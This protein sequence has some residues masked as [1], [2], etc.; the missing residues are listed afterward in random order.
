M[1]QKNDHRTFVLGIDGVPHSFLMERFSKGEMPELAR[2]CKEN[3]SRRMNSVYPTVSSVAW[4]TFA[5]GKNPA[6][7]NIMGFVDREPNPFQIKIPID[8]DRRAKTIWREISEQG[9]SVIVINVPFTY[10][11]EEVNGILVSGFLCTD[12]EKASYPKDFSRYL[13]E[14]DYIIDV[15]AWL[16]KENKPAFM[17]G[18]HRALEKRFEIIFEL[19]EKKPWDYCH[20]HIMETDRLFHFFWSEFNAPGEFSAAIA[21]FFS[22]LDSFIGELQRRLSNDDSLLILSDHGFCTTQYEVQLNVWL[23]QQGLLKF[24]REKKLPLYRR[25]SLC[26]SLLPGRI[27]INLEGREERGSVKSKDYHALRHDLKQ[28]LLDFRHPRT[29]EK[30]IDKVF[31]REEIYS[32]P[33]LNDAA[34]II[35]DPCRGFDLKARVGDD[36]QLFENTHISGMHT[37]DDAFLMARN[38][39][40][41]SV[42]SIQDVKAA[43]LGK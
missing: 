19:M 13:K 26:Y 8:S 14:K 24:D 16:A 34:D 27:Y 17:D 4:A 28:R 12:I 25:D 30:I 1:I 7:H 41:S 6:E 11:P 40:I 38:C 10:P 39:N 42:V 33:Y 31:F 3:A 5:T 35:A 20:L 23:Q 32:G 43:I 22:K 18:L 37:Y 29:G 36:V 9:K 2:L 21:S 15:D